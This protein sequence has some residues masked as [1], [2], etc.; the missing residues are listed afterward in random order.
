[1]L[2]VHSAAPPSSPLMHVNIKRLLQEGKEALLLGDAPH[3]VMSGGQTNKWLTI[4]CASDI[5]HV[6]GGDALWQIS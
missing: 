5:S 6:A 1:M 4:C 3:T 2:A